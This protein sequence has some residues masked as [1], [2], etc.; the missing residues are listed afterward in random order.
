MASRTFTNKAL[1]IR[2]DDTGE[3]YEVHWSGKSTARK[4]S[5]FIAPIL[6]A[7][8]KQAEL[9]NKLVVLDFTRVE[10]MNSSTVTPVIRVLEEARRKQLTVEVVYAADLKWQELSFSALRIFCDEGSSISIL[11]GATS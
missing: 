1:T 7:T 6:R 9:E 10:Y 11:A 2:V 5:D 4:P 8:L 3:H